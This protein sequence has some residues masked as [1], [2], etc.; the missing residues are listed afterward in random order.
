MPEPL[1]NTFQRRTNTF[2][3]SSDTPTS[4]L[5][6]SSLGPRMAV[7]AAVTVCESPWFVSRAIARASVTSS[8]W[9]CIAQSPF[10]NPHKERLVVYITFIKTMRISEIK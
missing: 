5:G 2:H 4:T 10:R 7:G 8:D 3:S 6:R 1:L 9:N